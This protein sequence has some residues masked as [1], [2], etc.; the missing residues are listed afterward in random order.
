MILAVAAALSLC[1]IPT[2]AT[3]STPLKTIEH[4][5]ISALCS[6][7]RKNIVQS[8]FGLRANDGLIR[9]GGAMIAKISVDAVND[10][11]GIGPTGGAG[12]SSQMDDI[13]LGGVVH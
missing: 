1:S 6:T 11:H 2:P 12:A 4:V 10:P 3:P 9:L 5:T 8:I 7:L 13:Q